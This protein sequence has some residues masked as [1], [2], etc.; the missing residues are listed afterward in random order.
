MKRILFSFAFAAMLWSCKTGST[1]TATTSK[2]EVSVSINL[3]DVKDDKVLVTVTTPKINTDEVTYSIPKIVPGTYTEDN[4]GKYIEDVKAFDAKGALLSVTKKDDNNW[5]IKNAK[6][7]RTITY[8]VNDTYDTENGKGFGKED[9][10]SPAGTNID[11]GVNFMINM[12]GFVGYFLDKIDL[13]YKVTISH[14]ETLWGATSMIDLDTTATTD[15]FITSRYAELVENPVMYAKPDYTTFTVDGMDILIGVYSPTGKVTAESITPE[16]KTMMTAQKT[17]LGKINA[18]KKYSVLLYLSTMAQTDAKGFGAL[19]HPTA[20]TVVLPEMLPKEELVKSMKDVVSHEFFH[21]VTPLT[22]HSK[23][24]QYFDYNAPKMSEHLWL[25]E[26]V[27]EYFA[28]LFQINQGL[29]D[30]TEFYSRIA[31]KIEHAKKLNDTMPFTTMSANVLVA[32]YKDQYLNVYE[33]GALIG[34]CIDIIIREKSNGERGILDMMHQLANEYGV[35]KPF[36]DNELFA[37]I[38]ELTYPEVGAF[39]TQYVSGPTPIPYETYLGKVGVTKAMEK[40]PGNVFLKG[41]M[42]YITVNPNTKEISVIPSSESI[43]FYKNLGLKGGDIIVAINEKPYSLDNIYEMI[44]ESQNWKENDAITLKIK[45]DGKE[46]TIKGKVK[47]P[48]EEK[49]GLKATDATKTTLKNTWLK[50]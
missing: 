17:F 43:D 47:L 48:Y 12:H 7:L 8:L 16:M 29:I 5:T 11:A 22:I 15:V 40:A 18:N 1:A 27:T 30:E 19:E 39:L 46:Q 41:Q 44:S 21:I 13:P 50:G 31:E 28:N 49:E 25:Y 23:E 42:P 34:M 26:G 10:F 3:I 14:P 4:Y 45:R 24:I 37:K 36:N 9:V 2:Q 6:A 32:P 38:T 35:S 20:T 33:K